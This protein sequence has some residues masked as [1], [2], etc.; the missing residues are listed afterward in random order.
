[1]E[2]VLL[3]EPRHNL[4]YQCLGASVT[5]K[6]HH[7]GNRANAALA[8]GGSPKHPISSGRALAFGPTAA[9]HVGRPHRSLTAQTAAPPRSP[10]RE[11]RNEGDWKRNPHSLARGGLQA[12][13]R[14]LAGSPLQY[15]GRS[16]SWNGSPHGRLPASCP[17]P[18]GSPRRRGEAGIRQSHRACGR[19]GWGLSDSKG[20]PPPPS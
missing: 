5:W 14:A 10:G 7:S 12:R 11:Q 1:M 20:A 2:D 9:K 15:L 6:N 4:K 16:R 19:S 18:P 13:A 3:R 17:P 8:Y